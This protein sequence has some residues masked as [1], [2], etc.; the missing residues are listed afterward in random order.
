MGDADSLDTLLYE[1]T[2]STDRALDAQ[3]VSKF[4]EA[5]DKDLDGPTT[6]ARLL[7][8]KIQSPQ[9]QES[10]NALCVTDE[11][12]RKC[13][14]RFQD[15]IGK[16]RFLNEIIKMISPKYFGDKTSPK[17]KTKCIEL[18]YRWSLD[19]RHEPKIL[20]A[21]EML[22]RQGIIDDDP[23]LGEGA[24]NGDAQGAAADPST[25]S[26]DDQTS[27][28][29]FDDEDKSKL[30][31]RLLR[32]KHPDDL[33]AANRLIKNMVKQD[34]EKQEKISQR[35]N[36]LETVRNNVKLLNEM[37][38][39]YQM[40]GGSSSSDTAIIKELFKNI[41]SERP[42]LFKLASD[43]E[44]SDSDGMSQVLQANDD[45]VQISQR[46]KEVIAQAEAAGDQKK[47][48]ALSDDLA[49]LELTS[50]SDI[51][52]GFTS[53]PV[54]TTTQNSTT[55]SI[56]DLFSTPSAPAMPSAPTTA[57]LV[58]QAPPATMYHPTLPLVNHSAPTL[59]AQHSVPS[60]APSV[61]PPVTKATSNLD[62]LFTFNTAPL[63]VQPL[64]VASATPSVSASAN[65]ASES[66][67]DIGLLSLDGQTASN[68]GLA[69]PLLPSNDSVSL[70]DTTSSP[71]ENLFDS[72]KKSAM[73][74]LDFL[75][76]DLLQKTKPA[77]QPVI[78]KAAPSQPAKQSLNQLKASNVEKSL[79]ASVPSAQPTV[80]APVIVQPLTNIHVPI[81]TVKPGELPPLSVYDKDCV[82]LVIH[83]AQNKPREDVAVMVISITSTRD[84]AI[85]SVIF[86]A[87]VPKSMKVK[88]Q[89]PSATELP[90]YNPILPPSAITQVLLLANPNKEKVKLKYKLSYLADGISVADT[91][92]IANFPL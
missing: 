24:T 4:C 11:C 16:F 77:Q 5:I 14:R 60:T 65:P 88:L 7:G 29:I 45:V 43:T 2:Q 25:N 85:K 76:Q 27:Q 31:A 50:N 82:K 90:A 64:S 66:G 62:D 23:I 86:Q 84:T 47:P 17:V 1:C 89:P 59:A 91:G 42:K 48:A 12:V 10:L 9:Q 55:S 57:A 53:A 52:S 30:L 8:H 54:A 33:Q 61:V 39:C 18:L 58:T 79:S 51:F 67:D 81:T 56:L 69:A 73:E 20:D 41:E 49:G 38:D 70:F 44:G 37:L 21:Y 6:A 19:L 74:D 28:S 40:A 78:P 68:A 72:G 13:G 35:F 3:R 46:Y 71:D 34:E 15:E 75:G 83:F 80:S 92:D 63:A 36:L 26:T 87:A 32:S 22:K